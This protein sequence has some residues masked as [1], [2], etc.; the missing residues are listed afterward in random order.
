MRRLGPGTLAIVA[1]YM[2]V[3]AH[4]ELWEPTRASLLT[5]ATARGIV[6]CNKVLVF[7]Q[8]RIAL[9]CCEFAA[10]ARS[11]FGRLFGLRCRSDLV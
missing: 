10:A 5:V 8:A 6:T 3:F 2:V 4:F 7:A 9:A 11:C 1:S